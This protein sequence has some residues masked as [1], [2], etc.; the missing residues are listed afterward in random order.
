MTQSKKQTENQVPWAQLSSWWYR[1]QHR[2]RVGGARAAPEIGGAHPDRSTVDTAGG[3][4]R[5]SLLTLPVGGPRSPLAAAATAESV[6]R[7]LLTAAWHSP[8]PPHYQHCHSHL[9]EIPACCCH[10]PATATT[11]QSLCPSSLQEHMSFMGHKEMAGMHLF[12]DFWPVILPQTKLASGM[13]QQL[14]SPSSPGRAALGLEKHKG[15]KLGV[16]ASAKMFS[17]YRNNLK[18]NPTKYSSACKAM[19]TGK[20]QYQIGKVH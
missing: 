7:W 14:Q 19:V 20:K 13:N 9:W 3:A 4:C 5:W 6:C 10:T 17:E 18:K 12:A 8:P 1:T 11:G 16:K 15:L 2:W